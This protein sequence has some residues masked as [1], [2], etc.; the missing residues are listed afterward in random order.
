MDSLFQIQCFEWADQDNVGNPFEY[1]VV[2]GKAE[3]EMV[4]FTSYSPS[5][6]TM[7][8][9]GDFD[10]DWKLHIE[11]WVVDVLGGVTVALQK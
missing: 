9:P 7:L 11:I 6:D 8:P 3:N 4:F 5:F 10:N 2:V 1:M